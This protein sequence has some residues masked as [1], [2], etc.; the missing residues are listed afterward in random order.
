MLTKND[1][2]GSTMENNKVKEVVRVEKKYEFNQTLLKKKR[3]ALIVVMLCALMWLCSIA[4][5]F[6][7]YTIAIKD[8]YDSVSEDINDMTADGYNTGEEV[9]AVAGGA[10]MFFTL[11]GSFMF[12]LLFVVALF[13]VG[14]YLLMAII[15]WLLAFRN[16][17]SATV[18]C[19]ICFSIYILVL[20]V[21]S[22]FSIL[23]ISITIFNVIGLV[24]AV[25]HAKYT[26]QYRKVFN[27]PENVVLNN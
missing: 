25:L 8:T 5:V 4:F 11:A 7:N 1:V 3:K 10:R 19:W 9:L 18:F 22:L 20:M 6:N 2:G 27:K 21:T 13:F 23:G 14:I 12:A 26:V 16:K 24:I 15:A 17:K